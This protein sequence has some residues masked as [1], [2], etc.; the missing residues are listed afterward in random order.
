[1]KWKAGH[2]ANINEITQQIRHI[3]QVYKGIG[4]ASSQLSTGIRLLGGLKSLSLNNKNKY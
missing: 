2:N 4:A 3:V 1:M